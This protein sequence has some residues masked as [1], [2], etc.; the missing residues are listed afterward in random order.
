MLNLLPYAPHALKRWGLFGSA[1]RFMLAKSETNRFASGNTGTYSERDKKKLLDRFSQI[2]GGLDCAHSPYQ[3]VLIAK[4][5]LE[6]EAQGPIVECG[7]YKGGG[8]AKLSILAKM[9][10]R[11]LFICD[12]FAGLPANAA[13]DTGWG[14]REA[15]TGIPVWSEGL[16]TAQLEEV[17]NN[18]ARFGE[19]DVCTFV[20]GFF[21]DSLKDLHVSPACVFIDVDLISSARD[22]LKYL[23]PQTVPGGLWFTHEACYPN[24][25]RAILDPEW[26][27]DVLHQSPPV[28]FGAGSGLSDCATGLAYFTKAT[29]A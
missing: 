23:W 26:W 16:F 14:E 27:Q 24:Y 7:C 29:A 8:S 9:T 6:L 4:H 22:C 28:I 13:E 25:I 3:F 12:S 1:A 2:Q 15:G 17:K 11:K 19:S 10:G 5:L 20:P 18:V 21:K